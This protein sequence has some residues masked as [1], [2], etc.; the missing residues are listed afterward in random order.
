MGM[1]SLKGYFGNLAA[2]ATIIEKL[3][4]KQLVSNNAKLAATNK[5]LVATVKNISNDIM[6]LQR[7]TY[8]LNKTGVSRAAQRKRYP[9]LCPHCKK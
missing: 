2:A 9:T 1:K 8:Q 3:V 5:D 4:L 7:E 6:D